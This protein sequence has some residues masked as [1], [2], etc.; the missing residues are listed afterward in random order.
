MLTANKLEKIMELED[1][2]RTQYEEKLDAKTAELER[3]KAELAEQKEQMQATINQQLQAIT[4]LSSKASVN[5]KLEQ[6]N[7]ELSNRSE[8]LQEEVSQLKKRVK[9]LQKDLAEERTKVKELTQ[10]DP[11]KMKKNL[12]AN[13]KK[14][15]EKT[16]ANNLLQKSLNKTKGEK[17][18]LERKVKELESKLE[19]L[20][21]VLEEDKD[22]AA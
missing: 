22:E 1:S 7:R 16:D 17:A 14:L 2:L 21:T 18:E 10:Y 11:K 19:E 3:C 13:K 6:Q 9:T 8:N 12:E 20:Q 5:Q 4:E 15:A